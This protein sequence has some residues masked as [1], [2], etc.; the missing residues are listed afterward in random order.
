MGARL[1]NIPKIQQR[2]LE[3]FKSNK[4]DKAFALA[5]SV[6]LHKTPFSNA[7]KFVDLMNVRNCYLCTT[8][9]YR[10]YL[11]GRGCKPPDTIE[12]VLQASTLFLFWQAFY[13]RF[14]VMF[15][16]ADNKR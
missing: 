2:C 4:T 6:R 10:F 5:I 1:V 13:K 8:H 9:D 7:R 16:R 11:I 15:L 14:K 12:A 3:L